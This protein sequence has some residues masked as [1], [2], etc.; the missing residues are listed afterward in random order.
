MTLPLVFAHGVGT[1]GDLPLPFGQFAW[2]AAAAVVISFLALGLLWPRH[3]LPDAAVGTAVPGWLDR[4]VRIGTWP[5]KLVVLALF[6]LSMA[7]GISGVNSV[8]ANL[9]PITVYVAFWVGMQVVSAIFGDVWRALS[10]FETIADIADWTMRKLGTAG[11]PD[12]DERS[13]TT[14][15]ASIAIFVF[16]WFELAYHDGSTPRSV[17]WGM[18]GYTLVLL[19]GT[20]RHGRGWLRSSD[21]FAVLFRLIAAMAPFYRSDD[22]TLRMRP[23]FSGLA[24]LRLGVDS[25]VFILV[26]LGGTT[27]DGLVGTELWSDVVGARTGWESTLTNTLGLLWVIAIVGALYYAATRAVAAMT[28]ERPVDVA[29]TFGHAL[30]PIVLG[31]AIAHYFSLLVLDGQAFP[32]RLSDPFGNGANWFGT[33]DWAVNFLLITTTTIAWVQALSIVVGHVAGVLVAHDRAVERFSVT[34]AIRTQYPMLAVMVIYT[35]VGLWLLLS[36]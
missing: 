6:V 9:A 26:V 25:V 28:E 27:F 33:G 24:T 13:F 17:G 7:A 30:I 18:L 20:L 5:A 15:P 10:P 34:E 14:W 35:V 23:P 11:L 16:L 8:D 2:G 31:Y 4:I 36:A 29:T 1:R 22:G 32:I 3:K 19:V 21:A 12:H